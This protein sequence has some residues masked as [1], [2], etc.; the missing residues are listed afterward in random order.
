MADP[1]PTRSLARKLAEVMAAVERIPKNGHNSFHNYDY[2]TEADIVAAVRQ[3]LALRHI[4]LLPSIVGRTREPVG[5]KGVVLTHL[6]MEFTFMD[7]ESG[8][9]K[10]LPWLGAGTDKEDKGAYKAMTG[11]EKY[12]LLKTFLIPTGDDPEQEG[13]E[14]HPAAA[15]QARSATPPQRPAAVPPRQ[16]AAA[17]RPAPRSGG[18]VVTSAKVAKTGENAKG[19]WTLYAVKF[20][21]G[22]EGTTFSKSMYQ[23]AV[24]AQKTGCE[25]DAQ[26]DA[27]K[28][29]TT[30]EP[31]YQIQSE[32]V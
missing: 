25:V 1:I 4:I 5:D 32:L 8:E 22:R 15:Q 26:I 3:E 20:S 23:A 18:L 14:E 12:F 24:D 21:D 6:D 19:P 30:L 2:A 16:P 9:E 11:G 10:T 31:A 28:N 29:L 13:D 27:K 7:G 17:P